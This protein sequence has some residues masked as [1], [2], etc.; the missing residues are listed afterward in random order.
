MKLDQEETSLMLLE[1]WNVFDEVQE[2]SWPKNQIYHFFKC[3]PLYVKLEL[4]VFIIC[5]FFI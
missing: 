5:F 1:Y 2:F 3:N 4:L